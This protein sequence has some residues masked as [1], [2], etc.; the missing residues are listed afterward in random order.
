MVHS[1]IYATYVLGMKQKLKIHYKI[2]E[3]WSCH[4]IGIVFLLKISFMGEPEEIFVKKFAAFVNEIREM[5]MTDIA[6]EIDKFKKN[7]EV[8]FI[9]FYFISSRFSSLSIFMGDHLL[10]CFFWLCTPVVNCTG[11]VPSWI[12]FYI[13]CSCHLY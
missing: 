6:G 13:V 11:G 12:L 4:E 2:S 9:L 3:I 8:H 10:I 5:P 1:S 7:C